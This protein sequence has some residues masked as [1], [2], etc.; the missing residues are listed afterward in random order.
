MF[1]FLL[2]VVTVLALL[3][4]Q[5][6]SAV[7]IVGVEYLNLQQYVNG[8]YEFTIDFEEAAY[9]SEI[10]LFNIIGNEQPYSYTYLTIFD[11]NDEPGASNTLSIDW[12]QW[13]GFYAGVYTGGTQDDSLDHLLLGMFS[14]LHHDQSGQDYFSASWNSGMTTLSLWFDDQIGCVDASGFNVGDDNDFNDMQMTMQPVPE[15]ATML[16]LGTGLIGLA[17]V[18][19]RRMFKD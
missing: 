6:A 8:V 17:G 11:K 9:E 3:L 5:P 10:G 4:A 18:G 14:P 7:P 19:R 1:K 16:L 13:D 12:T 2:V 15:P